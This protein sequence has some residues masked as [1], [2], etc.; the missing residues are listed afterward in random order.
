[1]ET[2]S[3][4]ERE[5][6]IDRFGVVTGESQSLVETSRLTGID[7]IRVRKIEVKALRKLMHPTRLAT[8]S[9]LSL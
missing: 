1:M 2:L 4:Q 8:L 3:P 7:P 9:Q 5:V 6:L